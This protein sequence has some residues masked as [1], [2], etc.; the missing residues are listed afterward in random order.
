ML[1]APPLIGGYQF[2]S[3]VLN[4]SS[5]TSLPKVAFQICG[6]DEVPCGYAQLS[7]FNWIQTCRWLSRSFPIRPLPEPSRGAWTVPVAHLR[8][9]DAYQLQR[10]HVRAANEQRAVVRLLP[11]G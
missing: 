2:M 10:V 7:R 6:G 9:G 5:Q 3:V 11:R 4:S 1:T 8:S